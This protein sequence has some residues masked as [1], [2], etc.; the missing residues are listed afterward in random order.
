MLRTSVQSVL[1]RSRITTA[2]AQSSLG[3]ATAEQFIAGH[4][5]TDALDVVLELKNQGLLATVERLLEEP[6]DEAGS[7]TNTMSYLDVVRAFTGANLHSD[8]DIS[9]DLVVLGL[10]LE[11]GELIATENLMKVCQAAAES[12]ISVTITVGEGQSVPAIVRIAHEL[13]P[14]FSKIGITLQSALLRSEQD[15]EVFGSSGARVRLCKGAPSDSADGVY[16]TK[17]DIDKAFVREV[18]T[19]LNSGTYVM[20]ATHDERLIQI[21]QA[22][23]LRGG[24]AKESF[25][26][27]LYLGVAPAEQQRLLGLGHRVRVH[28]PFGE[29]WLPIVAERVVRKPSSIISATRSLFHRN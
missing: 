18:R 6:T 27:Q 28:V 11:N 3:E 5:V 10:N 12:D 20:V 9:V 14:R 22:L 4:H 26:F 21:S 15:V 29:Q 25:E 13:A 16:T 23:A 2:F 17:Q 24:R 8:L 19:L 7:R 1:K